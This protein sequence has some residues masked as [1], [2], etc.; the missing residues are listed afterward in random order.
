MRILRITIQKQD[1]LVH[2]FG[3]LT[4]NEKKNRFRYKHWPGRRDES[5]ISQKETL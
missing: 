5:G 3:I 1:V 2:L 4:I